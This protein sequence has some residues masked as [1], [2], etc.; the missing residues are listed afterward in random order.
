[1]TDNGSPEAGHGGDEPADAGLD[2]APEG[3]SADARGDVDE[4]AE[5]QRSANDER[6]LRDESAIDDPDPDQPDP[7]SGA[8]SG[9]P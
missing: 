1:M 5:G 4:G 2:A 9:A 6:A 3:A 7:E 8:A